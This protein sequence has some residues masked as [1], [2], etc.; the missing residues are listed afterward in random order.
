[1]SRKSIYLWIVIGLMLVLFGYSY[2]SGNKK[3]ANTVIAASY[4]PKKDNQQEKI[5]PPAPDFNLKDLD[6]KNVRLSDQKG[7]VVLI[8][9]WATWCPPCRKGI[10]ELIEMQQEYGSDKFVV[11]GINLDQ[12]E[13]QVVIDFARNYQINYPVL[14]YTPEVVAAYGGIEA[15]PTSFVVDKEGR[16]RT[17][18]Q[19][20]RPKIFFTRLI[21]S[22]L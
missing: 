14:L 5:Y 1:M 8:D 2:Y 11:L 6:G 22:L 13:A 10:P 17:G 12:E 15:I 3:D 20:Y 16:V 19:G 4:E 21:D 9:F 18:V 7:K